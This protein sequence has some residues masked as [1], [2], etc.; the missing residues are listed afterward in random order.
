MSPTAIDKIPKFMPTSH[1]SKNHSWSWGFKVTSLL[2]PITN[3]V[4][5]FYRRKSCILFYFT[6]LTDRSLG[7][8]VIE[9]L[10]LFSDEK[11]VRQDFLQMTFNH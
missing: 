8:V 2:K 3:V 1:I 6:L 5:K 9:F 4:L 11:A 10:T 7:L